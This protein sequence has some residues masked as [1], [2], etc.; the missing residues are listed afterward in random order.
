MPP[1]FDLNHDHTLNS[2]LGRAKKKKSKHRHFFLFYAAHPLARQQF[3]S[4]NYCLA[5]ILVKPPV[6]IIP[7]APS[8]QSLQHFPRVSFVRKRMSSVFLS[9]P[10][11]R[12][13]TSLVFRHTLIF[14]NIQSLYRPNPRPRTSTSCRCARLRKSSCLLSTPKIKFLMIFTTRI[15]SVL[16]VISKIHSIAVKCSQGCLYGFPPSPVKCLSTYF[17]V[18]F[19]FRFTPHLQVYRFPHERSLT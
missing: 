6:F 18:L 10:N 14:R 9:T 7:L 13:P 8:A 15:V 19:I 4:K 17:L 2:I 3:C 16:H 5:T 11:P 12:T 1:L